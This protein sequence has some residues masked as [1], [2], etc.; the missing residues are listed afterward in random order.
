MSSS[1]FLP[2]FPK[3][4]PAKKKKPVS[5]PRYFPY[6]YR[7]ETF[8]PPPLIL[9]RAGGHG[10]SPRDISPKNS[11]FAL[12]HNGKNDEAVERQATA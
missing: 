4:P 11:V 9:E 7:H 6:G 5:Q 2:K 8:F 3:V 1:F 12:C 10:P